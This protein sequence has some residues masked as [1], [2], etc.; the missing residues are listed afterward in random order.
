MRTSASSHFPELIR[1]QHEALYCCI[2]KAA[3]FLGTGI[4]VMTSN[5]RQAADETQAKPQP[6]M[7]LPLEQEGPTPEELTA[8]NLASMSFIDA[9]TASSP[10]ATGAA[11]CCPH[12]MAAVEQLVVQHHSENAESAQGLTRRHHILHYLLACY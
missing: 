7:S 1:T 8:E 9:S 5:L 3:K 2:G 12:V 6:A 11:P 10:A 4:T